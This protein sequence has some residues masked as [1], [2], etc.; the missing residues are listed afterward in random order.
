MRLLGYCQLT[1]Q[2]LTADVVSFL[3]VTVATKPLFHSLS[4]VYVQAAWEA[5]DNA[6]K[7][8]IK[9]VPFNNEVIERGDPDNAARI[10]PFSERELVDKYV[11]GYNAN[12]VI[13]RIWST[14]PSI[15][16]DKYTRM[17]WLLLWLPKKI[18]VVKPR[19]SVKDSALKGCYFFQKHFNTVKIAIFFVDNLRVLQ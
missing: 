19:V 14:R 16:I 17:I 4:T 10:T 8:A 18:G 5:A 11:E 12:M 2:P 6:D 1:D 7:P 13:L 9:A 3:T 15:S